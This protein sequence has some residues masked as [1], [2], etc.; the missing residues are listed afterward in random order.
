MVRGRKQD[1]VKKTCNMKS[2]E[3]KLKTE[4]EEIIEVWRTY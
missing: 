1:R 4:R 2:K 3:N